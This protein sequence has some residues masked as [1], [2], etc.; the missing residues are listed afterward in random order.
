[1]TDL[2]DPRQALAE[3]AAQHAALRERIAQCE[4]LA[5]E[6]DRGAAD[7][8]QLVREVAALRVA[9]DAHNQFEERLLRPVLIDADWLGAVRAA[10]MVED[11]VEEHRAIRRGFEPAAGPGASSELRLVLASLLEHLD[12]E[13]RYFL[14]RKVLR[15]D[16]AR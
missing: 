5:D 9:F 10:R 11:H 6:L 7:P 1:M 8:A 3:L 2:A 13:E 15:A 16:L 14:S 4:A 12:S